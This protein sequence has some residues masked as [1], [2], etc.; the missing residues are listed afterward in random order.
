M[1]HGGFDQVADV[2]DESR[3]GRPRAAGFAEQLAER[4]SL[5]ELVL[6]VGVGTGIVAEELVGL[7]H[8]VVG[9]DVAPAMLARARQRL[10]D[11]VVVADAAALPLTT[12]A[13]SQAIST[14]LLH[15][16]PD[17]DRVF[18][19]VARVLRPGGSWY[20]IPA[21]TPRPRDEI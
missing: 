8:R 5:G 11:V 15:L 7:G 1:M 19:E 18:G 21:R 6:D 12:G 16:V 14:W 13:V 3:G 2:Y 20:T 9:V 10:G 4:L 17:R